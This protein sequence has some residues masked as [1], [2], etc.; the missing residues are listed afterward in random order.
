MIYIHL[1]LKQY[2]LAEQFLTFFQLIYL[3]RA[4]NGFKYDY[5]SCQMVWSRIKTRG[6]QPT[7][8]ASC[9]GVLYGSKWYIAGGGSRKKRTLDLCKIHHSYLNHIH[10]FL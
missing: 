2:V 7:P 4:M 1:T 8:R 9:C 10:N 3:G 6:F 5:F